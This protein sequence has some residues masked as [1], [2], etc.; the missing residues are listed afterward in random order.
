MGFAFQALQRP[1]STLLDVHGDRW[2]WN[3]PSQIGKFS[4]VAKAGQIPFDSIVPGHQCC[5]TR[6]AYRPVWRNQCSASEGW[7]S[8]CREES[9]RNGNGC[10]FFEHGG[11]LLQLIVFLFRASFTWTLSL[12]RKFPL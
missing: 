4:L 6:Q 1:C 3:D 10:Q 7:E 11:F 12:R 5:C 8:L 2:E 9:E